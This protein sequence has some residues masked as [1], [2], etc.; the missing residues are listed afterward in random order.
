MNKGFERRAVRRLRL[1]L[2]D[3]IAFGA[4][5]TAFVLLGAGEAWFS[6]ALFIKNI[7]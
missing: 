3:K 2:L 4:A 1:T 7:L 6:V 5:M